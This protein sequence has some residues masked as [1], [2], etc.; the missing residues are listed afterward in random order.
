MCQFSY[1]GRVKS[2]AL[3]GLKVSGCL[4]ASKA[5]KCNLNP[6]HVC[7]YTLH[8]CAD[9]TMP[10]LNTFTLLPHS[11]MLYW[12]FHDVGWCW[13][14]HANFF[15]WHSGL[16]C[17]F[18]AIFRDKSLLDVW[19]A[20]LTGECEDE[21]IDREIDRVIILARSYIL[22][23]FIKNCL[24]SSVLN[25]NMLITSCVV[26]V[27]CCCRHRYESTFITPWSFP[28][29]LNSGKSSCFSWFLS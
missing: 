28:F 24:F 25:H 13:I 9:I 18:V 7:K 14:K 16:I 20:K 12:M 5:R 23:T 6:T 27:I 19:T 21:R 2:S 1:P 26:F 8:M 10:F 4:L 11:V 15:S 17:L 22:K 29:N 3:A